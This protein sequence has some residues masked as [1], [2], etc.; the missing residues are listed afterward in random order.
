VGEAV[1]SIGGGGLSGGGIEEAALDGPGAAGFPLRGGHIFDEGIFE[2]ANG[3]EFPDQG[4][5][6]GLESVGGLAIE[7]DGVGE[8]AVLEGVQ[9]GALFPIGRDRAA[10]AGA[11]GPRG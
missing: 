9:G 7:D 3:L 5:D 4:L 10:G 8:E 2:V 11:I 6:E 1:Q